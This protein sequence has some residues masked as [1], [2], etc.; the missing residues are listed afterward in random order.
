MRTVEECQTLDMLELRKEINERLQILEFGYDRTSELFRETCDLVKLYS[1]NTLDQLQR[2]C[3]KITTPKLLI[4]TTP[5]NG[6]RNH[7]I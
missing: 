2:V 6:N 1:G 4:T 3:S 5:T 7:N